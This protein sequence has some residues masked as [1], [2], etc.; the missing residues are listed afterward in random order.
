MYT[1]KYKNNIKIELNFKNYGI[2]KLEIFKLP[3]DYIHAWSFTLL[4]KYLV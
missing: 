1:N 4:T 3:G 2:H